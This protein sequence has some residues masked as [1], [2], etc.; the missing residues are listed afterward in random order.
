MRGN[1]KPFKGHKSDG[2][3]R[4]ASVYHVYPVSR[5]TSEERAE[6]SKG[7]FPR[8]LFRSLL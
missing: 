8:A 2:Y 4:N 5:T 1:Y 7:E 6:S 3:G